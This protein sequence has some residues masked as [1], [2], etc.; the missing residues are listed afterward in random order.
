[1]YSSD[2]NVTTTNDTSTKESSPNKTTILL[3]KPKPPPIQTQQRYVLDRVALGII[4]YLESLDECQD[5][6]I[7]CTK[8]ISSYEISL[9][10]KRYAPLKLPAD[11]KKFYSSVFNGFSIRWSGEF[12]DQITPIGEI[13]INSMDEM[14]VQMVPDIYSLPSYLPADVTPP[15]LSTCTLISLDNRCPLGN[16][17]LLYRNPISS[18]AM[19]N[20]SGTVDVLLTDNTPLIAAQSPSITNID[21][22]DTPEVWLITPTCQ[23]IYICQSFIQ[24]MRLMITHLGIFQWQLAF[25]DDGLPELTSQYLQLFCKERL[26]IDKHYWLHV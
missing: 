22:L 13:R 16:V 8:E 2:D 20:G 24:Y 21:T 5:I 14:K 12:S 26:I 7:Q 3:P 15:N 11:V 18:T 23:L 17:V 25:S 6:S 19:A 10:E 9:W 4:T 1:M